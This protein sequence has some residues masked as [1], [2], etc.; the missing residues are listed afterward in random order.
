MGTVDRAM[1]GRVMLDV[2]KV[3]G[4]MRVMPAVRAASMRRLERGLR[5]GFEGSGVSEG[6]TVMGKVLVARMRMSWFLK[7]AV[8]S[9]A[10]KEGEIVMVGMFGGRVEVEVE[11]VRV[12]IVTLKFDEWLSRASRMGRPTLPVACKGG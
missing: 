1:E 8:S 7:A 12:R 10:V 2:P 4:M 5:C 11:L 6:A 3:E 9:S